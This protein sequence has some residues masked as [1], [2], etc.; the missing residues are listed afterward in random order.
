M[1]E[2][3]REYSEFYINPFKKET[4]KLDMERKKLILKKA[5]RPDKSF[6]NKGDVVLIYVEKHNNHYYAI[7]GGIV[8]NPSVQ[9]GKTTALEV[10]VLQIKI[11]GDL[12]CHPERIPELPFNHRYSYPALHSAEKFAN[13]ADLS[14]QISRLKEF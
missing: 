3:L 4:Y 6:F 7:R 5:Y 2:N 9:R 13:L 10:E 14:E 8:L 12:K 1:C 11:T